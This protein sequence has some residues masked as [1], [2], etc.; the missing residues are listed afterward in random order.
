M[1]DR[2]GEDL[3]SELR[4][5]EL[6]G[7]EARVRDMEAAVMTGLTE[8]QRQWWEVPTT[9][10]TAFDRPMRWKLMRK[11]V[12]AFIVSPIW[13]AMFDLPLSFCLGQGNNRVK[14]RA[15]EPGGV[16]E[17]ALREIEQDVTGFIANARE[18]CLR[19]MLYGHYVAPA[20]IWRNGKIT[21]CEWHPYSLYDGQFLGGIDKI[22]DRVQLRDSRSYDEPLG[23]FVARAES[24]GEPEWEDLSPD[25]RPPTDLRSTRDSWWRAIAQRPLELSWRRGCDMRLVKSRPTQVNQQLLDGNCYWA[26]FATGPDSYGTIW[27]LPSLDFVL[28]HQRQLMLHMNRVSDLTSFVYEVVVEGKS[29]DELREM[30]ARR[31]RMTPGQNVYASRP[32]MI[33]AVS[34]DLKAYE[35]TNFF[36]S[37]LQHEIL[38]CGLPSMMFNDVEV[39]YATA[40]AQLDHAAARMEAL[41][42]DLR[43]F[44]AL[45]VRYELETRKARGSIEPARHL[46]FDVVM[47]AIRVEDMERRARYLA[48]ITGALVQADQAGVIHHETA[49]LGV[50]KALEETDVAKIEDTLGALG[51]LGKTTS[52]P[53]P[54]KVSM[55]PGAVEPKTADGPAGPTERDMSSDAEAVLASLRLAR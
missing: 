27:C 37:V 53:V 52:V 46:G 33:R 17:E 25:Y 15:H 21:W 40:S 51:L 42:D 47:P 9:S 38:S 30:T 8:A 13:R 39:N 34:P 3:P 19:L 22:P 50:Q 2:A 55:E 54:E 29:E 14:L 6:A 32:G 16:V 18:C 49:A 10:L 36:K 7:R 48:V 5:M 1:D 31:E 43:A 44:L 20:I 26:R 12:E 4:S 24:P 35:M 11:S 41:Q 28:R 23:R 45:P